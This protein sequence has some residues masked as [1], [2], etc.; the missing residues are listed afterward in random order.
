MLNFGDK[1]GDDL[2]LIVYLEEEPGPELQQQLIKKITTFDEVE[3][4]RF[5]SRAEAYETICQTA[6]K[7][8][9]CS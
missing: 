6:G 8:P 2:S 4:I 9:G 1:L 7:K 3:K 5:I